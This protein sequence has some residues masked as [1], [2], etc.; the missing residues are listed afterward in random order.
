MIAAATGSQVTICITSGKPKLSAIN[1]KI[2]TPKPPI[3][4]LK[5]IVRPAAIPTLSGSIVCAK[6]I[7]VANDPMIKKPEATTAS[8][9][10]G[11]VTGTV[12]ATKNYAGGVA[13]GGG[14][15]HHEDD[16]QHLA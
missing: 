9:A 12:T 13:G 3:P 4:T 6:T 15:E 10:G 11:N 7:V 1:P 14:D 16:D 2:V 8:I 5:P